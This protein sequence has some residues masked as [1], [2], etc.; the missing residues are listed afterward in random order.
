MRLLRP[1]FSTPSRLAPRRSML[2][3]LGTPRLV[4]GRCSNARLLGVIAVH[5]NIAS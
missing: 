2:G 3:M 5:K 1:S 4:A